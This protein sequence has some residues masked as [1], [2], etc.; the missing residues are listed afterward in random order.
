MLQD[1]GDIK[2]TVI[3]ILPHIPFLYLMYSEVVWV[4][5]FSGTQ[6]ELQMILD[7]D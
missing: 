2:N 4:P 3:L 7:Q 1:V 6:A 5:L